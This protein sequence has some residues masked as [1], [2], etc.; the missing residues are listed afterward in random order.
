MYL[1]RGAL[2]P[3]AIPAVSVMLDV[4]VVPDSALAGS[5][6]LLTGLL[7]QSHFCYNF[8]ASSRSSC[9]IDSSPSP[10]RWILIVCQYVHLL[11][12]GPDLLL[13]SE[14]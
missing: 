7:L 8:R 14:S 12:S 1:Y 9:I 5:R 10:L 4:P 6:V 2:A 13:E 11:C 3:K